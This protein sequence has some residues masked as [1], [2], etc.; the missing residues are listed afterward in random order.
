LSC[1][2]S[3]LLARRIVAWRGRVLSKEAGGV[4]FLAPQDGGGAGVRLRAPG[5]CCG[6]APVS[7]PTDP[8]ANI[9]C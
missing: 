7:S 5:A 1:G 6:G 4:E 8:K 2:E 9:W 3:N